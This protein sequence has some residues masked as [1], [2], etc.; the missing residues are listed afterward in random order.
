MQLHSDQNDG[1]DQQATAMLVEDQSQLQQSQSPPISPLS[2]LLRSVV[3]KQYDAKKHPLRLSDVPIPRTL[4]QAL[5]SPFAAY[6]KDAYVR[7]ELGS[8]A[9]HGT[10]EEVDGSVP[11]QER[12]NIVGCRLVFACK[13][14]NGCLHR[15]KVRLV[16]RGFSQRYG[17]DYLETFSPVLKY[18]ALRVV[19][20]LVAAMGLKL[21]VMDVVTAY[22]N[23]ELKERVF[24]LAPP[25][26]EHYTRANNGEWRARVCLLRK[27]IYGLKQAGREWN[28]ELN[29]FLLSLGL[30]R[31]SS[32][33]CV[34]VKLSRSRHLLIVSAYVDDIPSAYHPAD[35]QEWGELKAMFAAKFSIKFL[36]EAEWLLNMRIT[37]EVTVDPQTGRRAVSVLL[38]QEAYVDDMLLELGIDRAAFRTATSPS[39]GEPLTRLQCPADGSEEQVRMRR[40]PYRKCIG[41]LTYLANT[42]RPDISHAVNQA[43]QFAQ[44]PGEQHWRAVKQILR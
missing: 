23:A 21:E 14:E 1:G 24:M 30:R 40:L 4:Q 5:A 15:F 35:Q 31:L 27:A 32:D 8:H 9:E 26:Y 22:L 18:K 43:A 42:S 34:Y 38:D 29:S 19:L 36:G 39:S 25:G 44:N 3:A 2:R 28:A 16:A 13:G 37:R 10:W 7:S 41:L 11:L 17:V 33:P 6:W 20:H 12:A